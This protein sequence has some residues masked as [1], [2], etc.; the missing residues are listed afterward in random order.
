ME[1]K[2]HMVVLSGKQG[3]GKTTITKALIKAIEQRTDWEAVEVRFAQAIYQMHDAIRDYMRNLGFKTPDKMGELL[4]FLGTD[5]GRKQF[6]DDVWVDCVKGVI[7]N[8]E[9]MRDQIVTHGSAE[10]Q[11]IKKNLLYVVSDCR[12]KNEFKAFP[13]AL[14]VRLHADEMVRKARADS[15]R[16]NVD[17][18]SETDLNEYDAFGMFDLDLDTQTVN[19][20]GCV[21]LI[22]AQLDKGSWISKRDEGGYF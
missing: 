21:T 7:R 1:L 15:W 3:S 13:E 14:R 11:G 10:E 18:P 5:F 17:H 20:T 8:V 2:Y 4:Q 16:E 12:F 19:V 9:T 22:L 6:G